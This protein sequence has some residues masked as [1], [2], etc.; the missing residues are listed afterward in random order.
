MALPFTF[1]FS[2]IVGSLGYYESLPWIDIPMHLLGGAAV[3]FLFIEG[4]RNLKS[5]ITLKNKPIELII[6]VSFVSLMAVLWEFFEFF[7]GVIGSQAWQLGLE[8]TLLDLLMGIVGGLLIG[9]LIDI[10]K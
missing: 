2:W 6:I 8:D 7:L 10:E 5:K 3:A 1:M 4:I 9:L